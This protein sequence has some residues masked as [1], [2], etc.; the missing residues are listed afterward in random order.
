MRDYTARL[1]PSAHTK[2][3]YFQLQKSTL[4][5]RV[6]LIVFS[7]WRVANALTKNVSGTVARF[8]RMDLQRTLTS[9]CWS[10]GFQLEFVHV[11]NQLNMA[12][13][14]K[15]MSFS[16]WISFPAHDTYQRRLFSAALVDIFELVFCNIF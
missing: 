8:L 15:K 1:Q 10:R 16:N 5:R 11:F 6:F 3:G 4:L 7:F 9:C 2:K 12:E 13:V 14:L